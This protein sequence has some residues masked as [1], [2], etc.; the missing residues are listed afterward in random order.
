LIEGRSL[1]ASEARELRLV[2]RVVPA[3][4]LAEDSARVAADFAAKPAVALTSL[5]RACRHLDK[6]L[7]T[8]LHNTGTGFDGLPGRRA[9]AE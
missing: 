4:A 8:Y 5:K 9:E 7:A 3:A 6:D 2:N 1:T